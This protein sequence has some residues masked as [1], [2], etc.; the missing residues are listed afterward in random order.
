MW[1]DDDYRTPT[2]CSCLSGGKRHKYKSVCPLHFVD[3]SAKNLKLN[4]NCLS[5]RFGKKMRYQ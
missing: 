1:I 2:K 3:D 4:K 5:T